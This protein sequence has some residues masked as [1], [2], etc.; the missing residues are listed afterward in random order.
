[1]VDETVP[2]PPVRSRG[3]VS[4][5]AL[6]GFMGAGKTTVGQELAAQIGWRFCDLDRLIEEREQRTVA[7]IFQQ[8]GEASFRNMELRLLRELTQS[9][10]DS[11]VLALGGG[12]FVQAPIQELLARAS[13]AT[14]FLDAPA[15]ELFRRCEQPGVDRPLRQSLE[16]F[17]ELYRRRR[18]EYLKA[19]LCIHTEA[20]PV[21]TI[22]QEIISRLTLVP[23]SG[24]CD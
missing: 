8:K 2:S 12:A 7:E 18:P 17:D 4:A 20:K 19:A 15:E 13:I 11:S 22:V 10:V 14:V 23:S 5:V 24:V 6:V 1:M 3:R 16:Q 21:A 9:G